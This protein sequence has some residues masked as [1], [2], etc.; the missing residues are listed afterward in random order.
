VHLHLPRR[1][2]DQ[3]VALL[4]ARDLKAWRD[5]LRATLSPASIN[6]ILNSLRAALNAAA[7]TDERIS[8]R[9]W[10]TGLKSLAGATVARNVIL[11]PEQVRRVVAAAYEVGQEFGLL[12]EVAATTGARVGQLARLEVA[13]VQAGRTDPRLMM[14]S[15]R[16]GRGVKRVTHQAVAIPQAL[17]T[18]LKAA[19]KGRAGHDP[20]L[21][22]ASGEPWSRS[23]HTRLFRRAVVRA[24]LDSKTTIYALRHS[25][26]VRQLLASVPIRVV[27]VFHDTSV[28]MIEKTYSKHIGDHADAL[29]RPA[30][31]DLSPPAAANVVPLDRRA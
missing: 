25:S 8:R 12:A 22:K 21:L 27:A 20:L 15:S 6:R 13:D 18:R 4:T 3:P 23:D 26:I 1:L 14:P 9:A 24:G 30:L 2:S 5:G 11:P 10:E 31:L 7:D 16:K 19:G 29:A 28:P 17:A